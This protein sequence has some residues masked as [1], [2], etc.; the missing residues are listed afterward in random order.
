LFNLKEHLTDKLS[1]LDIKAQL[2]NGFFVNV[3]VQLVNQ[4]DLKNRTL[5]Y[6]SRMYGGQLKESEAYYIISCKRQLP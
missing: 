3:K 1:I 4:K 2:K 5:Y 6:W